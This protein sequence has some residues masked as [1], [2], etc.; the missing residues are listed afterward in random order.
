MPKLT[1]PAPIDLTA[2]SEAAAP[3]V[4]LLAARRDRALRRGNT[5]A[6]RIGHHVSHAAARRIHSLFAA[7]GTPPVLSPFALHGVA[8]EVVEATA[9]HTE[10]SPAA[11]LV[12]LL[13]TFGAM[14]GRG[15]YI[16]VGPEHHHS[17]LFALVVGST[18]RA[19]KGT[20]LKAISPAI[21][22]AGPDA[23]DFL[24]RR[25]VGGLASGE[26]LVAAMSRQS[27]VKAVDMWEGAGQVDNRA[28]VIEEEFAGVLIS[29]QRQGSK[30]STVIR[31]LWD[32]N[33]L[34][35]TTK[36]DPLELAEP[37][38]GVLGHI[39][40]EE[41]QDTLTSTDVSSGFANRFLVV[42]SER[43]RLLPEPRPLPKN[44]IDAFGARLGTSLQKARC[45]GE[46][47]GRW[48]SVSYGTAGTERSR[49]GPAAD[50]ASTASRG[51][52]RRTCCGSRSCTR[53]W[54]AAPRW[55][56]RTFGRLSLSGSTARRASRT[57][58]A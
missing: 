29:A 47:T 27:S 58:G 22:A 57:C 56:R 3:T 51:G 17:S 5:D 38:A 20:S 14:V 52:R 9:P 13:T 54:T 32:G 18:G 31:Q 41:L 42:Y 34:H 33:D 44:V 4:D 26:G 16:A 45:T 19:R 30:L 8:G 36:T 55:T 48:R 2:G 10:A 6:E 37:H 49:M 50:G 23:E 1:S 40:A 35:V 53:C 21:A 7:P 28:L 15:A 24:A 25:K 46:V 43:S 39:T 11:M 12:S